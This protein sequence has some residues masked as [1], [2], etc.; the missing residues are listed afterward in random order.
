[1]NTRGIL[2][3]NLK[4]ILL[5]IILLI[6][7]KA[8][9][10]GGGIISVPRAAAA[11]TDTS[12]LTTALSTTTAQLTEASTTFLLLDTQIR[13]RNLDTVAA[14]RINTAL[15]AVNAEGSDFGNVTTGDCAG[16]GNGANCLTDASYCEDL[17]GRYRDARNN[18]L[19]TANS[20]TSVTLN[21]IVTT[22]TVNIVNGVTTVT[23][24]ATGGTVNGSASKVI[25][26]VEGQAIL[27]I[28]RATAGIVSL[29]LTL[30]THPSKVLTVSDVLA[31]YFQ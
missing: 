12:A 14:S 10:A 22:D 25:T 4:K 26:F 5:V 16:W 29:A 30:P 6:T 17:C 20:T 11:A 8:S 31:V 3:K 13:F 18:Y 19:G 23:V 9:F 7:A 1:M 27:Q 24:T 21:V 2:N 15:E 28:F